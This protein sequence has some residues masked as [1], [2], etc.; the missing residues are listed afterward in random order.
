MFYSWRMSRDRPELI[1][2]ELA[3]VEEYVINPAFRGW[4]HFLLLLPAHPDK[5]A[6]PSPTGVSSAGSGKMG[7]PIRPRQP[8]TWSKISIHSTAQSQKHVL[9]LH[10]GIS[11]PHSKATCWCRDR[12]KSHQWLFVPRPPVCVC[13]CV[14]V[15]CAVIRA[16]RLFSVCRK[17]V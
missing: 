9:P 2:D 4:S 13:V 15:L 5:S 1:Y 17:E 11:L 8:V 10:C 12:W 14:C 7:K 16:D 6:T 3:C